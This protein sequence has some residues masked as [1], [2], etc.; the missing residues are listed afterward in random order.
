M[1]T[2]IGEPSYESN[3]EENWNLP[4]VSLQ[5]SGEGDLLLGILLSGILKTF[6]F[7]CLR[8]EVLLGCPR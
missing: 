5:L 7:S 3:S 1:T 2:A 6:V 8:A 4:G